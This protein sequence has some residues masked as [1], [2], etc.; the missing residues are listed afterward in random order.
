MHIGRS[1]G[2]R[3]FLHWTRRRLY[4][5]AFITVLPV[6]IYQ[7]FG[8]RW[9]SV[10]WPVV[11][12]LGTA[13]SFIVGFKNSQTYNRMVTGQNV[14][15]AIEATSRYWGLL[16]RDFLPDR[17]L[18]KT[19]INRHLAWVNALR[20]E[21][22]AKR[23]WESS[24]NPENAE[25]SRRFFCV[26]EDVT[27][28]EVELGR[29]LDEHELL[30]TGK[31]SHKAARLMSGQSEMLREL[32]AGGSLLIV[33]YVEMQRTLKEFIGHQSAAESLKNCPYPRQYAIMNKIFVWSFAALLPLGVIGQFDS[34]NAHVGPLLSGHMAWFAFPFS[35]LISWLYISLDQVG[36][37]TEN[38]FQGG[39]NDVPMAHICSLIE[40]ELKQM[41]GESGLP[42]VPCA[43]H[44]IIL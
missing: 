35:M 12:V 22:R 7:V 38:P 9:I 16:C 39:A 20:Y 23:V 14:W 34:L 42:E 32:H 1:Y 17:D 27:P 40:I 41:L 44:D 3:E 21:L 31:T 10:P 26:P 19:L 28:V 36:E 43:N 33:H 11:A 37:S 8:L 6:V 24:F 2:L 25:Y 13:T 30:R 5:L 18:S 29:F 4:A 15:T